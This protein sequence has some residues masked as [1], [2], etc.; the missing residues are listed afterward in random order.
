MEYLDE[1]AFIVAAT[2]DDKT[3]PAIL[4]RPSGKARRRMH[5]VLDRMY[6]H[7]TI[8]IVHNAHQPL[9]TK[10]I[11]ADSAREKHQKGVERHAR[12]RTVMDERDRAYV[13]GVGRGRSRTN[14]GV[15]RSQHSVEREPTANIVHLA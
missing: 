8:R 7:W 6:D 13:I 1:R 15:L 10:E 11:G 4:V 2:N 5:Q 14:V 3:R 9:H 12:H